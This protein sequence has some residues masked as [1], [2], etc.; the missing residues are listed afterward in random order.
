MRSDIFVLS[1]ILNTVS[2]FLNMVNFHTIHDSQLYKMM[3][4]QGCIGIIQRRTRTYSQLILITS[5][6]I[7]FNSILSM[8]VYLIHF[9]TFKTSPMIILASI[10]VHVDENNNMEPLDFERICTSTPVLAEPIQI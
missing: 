6:V 8:L 7:V 2:E 3:N 9:F 5:G 10:L 1:I 4:F